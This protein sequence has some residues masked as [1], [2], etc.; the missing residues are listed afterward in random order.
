MIYQVNDI[1]DFLSDY[2]GCNNLN[3]DTDIFRDIGLDGDDFQEMMDEYSRKFNVDITSYLWYFH[4]NEEGGNSLGSI[5]FKPPYERVER[6]LLT[7]KM[8]ADFANEGV[9]KIDY[10]EHTLPKR[11]YDLMVNFITL[12]L[13]ILCVVIWAVNKYLL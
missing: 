12:C 2:S 1:I 3:S 6:I 4:G 13:V 10:P 9:W 7:P 5:F 11:R 8:L